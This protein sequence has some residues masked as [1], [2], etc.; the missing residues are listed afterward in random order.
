MNKHSQNHQQDENLQY[1]TSEFNQNKEEE[2]KKTKETHKKHNKKLTFL[3]SLF[4]NFELILN[5]TCTIMFIIIVFLQFDIK[6]EYQINNVI[7]DF[8]N[9]PDFTNKN[10]FYNISLINDYNQFISFRISQNNFKVLDKYFVVSPLRITQRRYKQKTDRHKKYIISSS[11]LKSINQYE[12]L[13][14]NPYFKGSFNSQTEETSKLENKYNFQMNGSFMNNGG[15]VISFQKDEISNITKENTDEIKYLSYKDKVYTKLSTSNKLILKLKENNSQFNSNF[16][17]PSSKTS[18]LIYDYV[19]YNSEIDYLVPV[20]VIFYINPSGTFTQEVVLNYVRVSLY[21]N[22]EDKFRLACEI[23]YLFAFGIYILCFIVKCTKTIRKDY[24]NYEFTLKNQIKDKILKNLYEQKQVRSDQMKEILYKNLKSKK[25]IEKE[26]RK[27]R[28]NNTIKNNKHNNNKK[29]KN[30]SNRNVLHIGQSIIKLSVQKNNE[31][32][33]LLDKE[34]ENNKQT[35]LVFF[36]KRLLFKYP[37]TLSSLLFSILSII[38]W[39]VYINNNNLLWNDIQSQSNKDNDSFSISNPTQMTN[40]LKLSSIDILYNLSSTLNSYRIVICLNLLVIF[41]RLIIVLKGILDKVIIFIKCFQKAFEDILS[42]IV[43]FLTFIFAFSLFFFIFF[44]KIT[45]FSSF[46]SCFEQIFLY[47]IVNIE[48]IYTEMYVDSP[49]VTVLIMML[50]IIYMRYILLK[51]ILAIL[52]FW[53]HFSA[54]KYE[55]SHSDK[56]FLYLTQFQIFKLPKD[57]VYRMSLLFI[58]VSSYLF[59]V[60][61]CY[62]RIIDR[63]GCCIEVKEKTGFLIRRKYGCYGFD[64]NLHRD[65]DRE[66]NNDNDYDNDYDKDY[67]KEVKNTLYVPTKIDY[68]HIENIINQKEI[69]EKI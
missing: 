32:N 17:F 50:L 29:K 40:Q 13:S 46:K 34:I 36:I 21:S 10:I 8:N 3:M 25:N 47:S 20:Y 49:V 45:K 18:L 4:S 1:L 11:E 54:N 69:K 7:K 62:K 53:F 31:I 61:F 41:S 43:I 67:D 59:K 15:Y 35:F 63:R 28:L 66:G 37:S 24:K 27:L 23:I 12:S 2:A 33:L 60:I 16:F 14:F 51:I 38:Y 42:Y 52:M 19:L 39:I 22:R 64:H 57:V 5:I 68:N 48:D 65:R 44:N 58:S 26:K 9:F 56:Q 30:V 55:D 6:K